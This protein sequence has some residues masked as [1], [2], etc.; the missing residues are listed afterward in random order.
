MITNPKLC[1]INFNGK[2]L[3]EILNVAKLKGCGIDPLQHGVVIVRQSP[4][5]T[6][7]TICTELLLAACTQYIF[8]FGNR[9][10]M[11]IPVNS[12]FCTILIQEM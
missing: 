3:L 10:F 8:K 9:Q 5:R 2:K 4:A 1:K 11:A 6:L 12:C 7:L